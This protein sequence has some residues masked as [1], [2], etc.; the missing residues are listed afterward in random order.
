MRP[1]TLVEATR[2]YVAQARAE[3][4]EVLVTDALIP[5]V[6]SLVAWGHEEPAI[7]AVVRDLVEA[8]EPTRVTV[9]Y[10]R[11]DPDTALRRA[12]DREG[13]EWADWF[14]GRL[15]GS[16]GTSSV[17]SLE[18]AAEHLRREAELTLR[19]LAATPWS[20]VTVDVGERSAAEVEECAR[21][22]L[23]GPVGR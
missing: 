20:V 21:R 4:V 17:D 8:V 16:P 1:G 13:P 3:G 2:A 9:V 12:V 23:A 19:L 22:E 18:A 15:A 5:F 7:S 11:D 6:P 10:L 14:V